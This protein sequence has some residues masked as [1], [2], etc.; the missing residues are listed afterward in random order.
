MSS[1]KR[2]AIIGLGLIGGSIAKAATASGHSCYGYDINQESISQATKDGVI[3]KEWNTSISCDIYIVA[4]YESDTI[5]FITDN[6]QN[7]TKGA[8]IIDICGNK[9]GICASLTELCANAGHCFIGTHPMQGRTSS[10]YRHS[11]STLFDGA[12]MIICRDNG[13]SDEA[14][15]IVKQLTYDL[16]FKKIVICTPDEHDAMLS[17]TSQLAH[18]LSSSYVQNNKSQ[19]H[20]GFSAGSFRDLSRVSELSADMWSE[21]MIN[22]RDNL[23]QDIACYEDILLQFKQKLAAS[24]KDGLHSLLS[25]GNEMKLRSKK[26]HQ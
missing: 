12:S 6:I 1:K 24:D 22:N 18:I 10:G 23:L 26:G 17:Y 15:E 9:R 25:K 5:K 8:V 11:S 4:L 7:F 2:I 20:I 16:K 13:T 21:L 14:I 19:K 3:C